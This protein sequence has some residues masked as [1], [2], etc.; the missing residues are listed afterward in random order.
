MPFI[1]LDSCNCNCTSFPILGDVMISDNDEAGLH[2][3]RG[4]DNRSILPASSSIAE[5]VQ[6]TI[7]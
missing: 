2:F 5:P 6:P 7:S 3:E 1:K 4:S